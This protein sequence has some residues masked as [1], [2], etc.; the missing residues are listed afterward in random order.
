MKKSLPIFTFVVG[1]T[2]MF[3]IQSFN[4]KRPLEKYI[5]QH[6][7]DIA[8]IQPGPHKGGGQTIAYPFFEGTDEFDIAFRKRTL[9]PGSSIGYHLQKEDEVYYILSG[10]GIMQMNGDSFAVK[11]GDAILTRPGSSHGLRPAGDNELTLLI[12]YR[13]R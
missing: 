7:K 4:E 6:E 9:Q 13:L 11:P 8:K 3:L 12:T 2:L 5:L 10:N 1:I